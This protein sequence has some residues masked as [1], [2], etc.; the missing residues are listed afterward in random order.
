MIDLLKMIKPWWRFCRLPKHQN[1]CKA[2]LI[3]F[4]R[5]VILQWPFKYVVW[6]I[7]QLCENIWPMT[8]NRW[9]KC[10]FTKAIDIDNFRRRCGFFWDTLYL[11]L[12]AYIWC[13][14]GKVSC[15]IEEKALH[16]SILQGTTCLV[17]SI[18]TVTL[19]SFLARR[20]EGLTTLS[21][22]QIRK[23]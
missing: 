2:I 23:R 21:P 16:S 3:T 20:Q 14:C 5:N 7:A 19:S 17:V 13:I 4:G 10:T 8:S 15:R 1:L 18:I 22:H 6:N 11:Y 12:P 9:T